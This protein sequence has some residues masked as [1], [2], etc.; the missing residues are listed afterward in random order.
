MGQSVACQ[1]CIRLHEGR[2]GVKRVEHA[3]HCVENH[4]FDT[5]GRFSGECWPGSEEQSAPV[6]AP[7]K[8]AASKTGCPTSRLTLQGTAMSVLDV[9]PWLTSISWLEISIAVV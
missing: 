6:S 2:I 9:I 1:S 5:H 8:R 7:R 4:G 3:L